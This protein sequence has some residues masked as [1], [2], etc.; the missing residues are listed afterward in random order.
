MLKQK[1]SALEARLDCILKP[2][3]LGVY[4][5]ELYDFMDGM[6]RGHPSWYVRGNNPYVFA[7][8]NGN[9][10]R[11]K[12]DGNRVRVEYKGRTRYFDDVNSL[13]DY[14]ERLRPD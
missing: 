2:C 6:K 14:L 1:L 5:E 9:D 10:V 8:L 4:L 11:V 3:F 12:R 13:R 7:D